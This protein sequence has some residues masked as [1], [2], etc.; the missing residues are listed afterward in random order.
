MRCSKRRGGQSRTTGPWPSGRRGR[1]GAGVPGNA[2][3]SLTTDRGGSTT[4]E[5]WVRALSHGS[6]PL[7]SR[8]R[9]ALHR[10]PRPG[11]SRWRARPGKRD[12]TSRSPRSAC[13]GGEGFGLSQ[14]DQPTFRKRWPRK[15]LTPPRQTK[16]LRRNAPTTTTSRLGTRRSLLPTSPTHSATALLRSASTSVLYINNAS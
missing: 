4:F 1:S 8:G 5:L 7:N 3:C 6:E 10:W 15:E 9:A 14:P 13:E 11:R 12:S 2:A 16:N